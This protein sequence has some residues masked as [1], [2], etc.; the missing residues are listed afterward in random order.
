M[1]LY[2]G[3][4][5]LILLAPTWVNPTDAMT[6]GLPIFVPLPTLHKKVDDTGKISSSVSSHQTTLTPLILQEHLSGVFHP[7]N[8]EP[9]ISF[10]TPQVQ[11]IPSGYI[12][13]VPRSNV[14]GVFAAG[15]VQAQDLYGAAEQHMYEIQRGRRSLHILHCLTTQEPDLIVSGLSTSSVAN[16]LSRSSGPKPKPTQAATY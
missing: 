3:P 7:T 6:H 11:T 5:Q 13:P 10:V 15:D 8:H 9:T 1:S 16:P 4:H 2:Y 14:K 12:L